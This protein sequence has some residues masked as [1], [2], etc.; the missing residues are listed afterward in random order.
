[1]NWIDLLSVVSAGSGLIAGAA[2]LV[3]RMRAIRARSLPAA[4]ASPPGD[5]T[6]QSTESQGPLALRHYQDPVALRERRDAPTAQVLCGSVALLNLGTGFYSVAT[7]NPMGIPLI[8]LGAVLAW[9]TLR[10]R[11]P[12]PTV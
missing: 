4:P 3:V 5:S 8:F 1:M 2:G 7:S 9:M 10:F 6:Q 12:A 11:N